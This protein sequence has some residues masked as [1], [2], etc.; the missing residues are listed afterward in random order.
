M[1]RLDRD[2]Q[3]LEQQGRELFARIAEGERRYRRMARAVWQVQEQERRN[4]ARDLHDGLG[5]NLTAVKTQLEWIDRTGELT[6]ET[7]L[8][9]RELV[10][11]VAG[12]LQDTR[13]MSRL[14]RP[15]MLDDLGLEPALRWLARTMA[16]EGDPECR[17]SVAVEGL[18]TRFDEGLETLI[19][20]VAQEAVTNAVRHSGAPN[21][22]IHL[23]SNADKLVLTV[24]D[25]GSGFDPTK[26]AG[27]GSGLRGMRDRA[28]LFD[29]HLSVLSTPGR[30]TRIELRLPPTSQERSVT[31]LRSR[32]GAVSA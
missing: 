26:L 20:R 16:C 10:E 27:G 19:F 8:R 21:I 23:V 4:L 25:N 22:G 9:V 31:D 17:V 3:R 15:S 12:A 29:G 11:I 7:A 32:A 30:G 13:E 2:L 5:Q 14:L 6:P 28:T 24:T 18:E 1:N